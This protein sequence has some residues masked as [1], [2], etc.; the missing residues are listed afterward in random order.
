MPNQRAQGKRLIGAMATPEL[1]AGVDAWLEAHP[2]KT[3]TQFLLEALME[4]LERE[5]ITVRRADVLRDER[6]R[7]PIS[8]S[9]KERI[10]YLRKVKG[11]RKST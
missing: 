5:R 2:N 7:V 6:A 3:V 8:N 4:K 9:T 10:S 11:S 1:W